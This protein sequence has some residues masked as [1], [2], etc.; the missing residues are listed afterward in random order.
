MLWCPFSYGSTCN[1]FAVRQMWRLFHVVR[2]RWNG[3]YRESDVLHCERHLLPTFLHAGKQHRPYGCLQ[4]QVLYLKLC[5]LDFRLYQ[6][7]VNRNCQMNRKLE[8]QKAVLLSGRAEFM[9]YSA[10]ISE[11]SCRHVCNK[12]HI[13]IHK[14]N[15]IQNCTQIQ[16]PPYDLGNSML[17]KRAF[18]TGWLKDKIRLWWSVRRHTFSLYLVR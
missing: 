16:S 2:P 11:P 3:Q 18:N 10:D 4:S 15:D 14:F 1:M 8:C 13:L 9:T 7:I 6:A 5:L 17:S 12:A